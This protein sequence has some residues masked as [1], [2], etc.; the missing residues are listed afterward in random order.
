MSGVFTCSGRI[1]IPMKRVRIRRNSVVR[2]MGE[3]PKI[4]RQWAAHGVI[5]NLFRVGRHR[6]SP[7]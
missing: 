4:T 1:P 5:N 2:S 3:F 6:L 7:S